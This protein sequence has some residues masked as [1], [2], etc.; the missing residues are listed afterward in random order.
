MTNP[1]ARH[2]TALALRTNIEGFIEDYGLAHCGLLT[3]V[4]PRKITWK[5]AAQNV[6]RLQRVVF[7]RDFIAWIGVVE[8][9]KDGRPHFHFLVATKENLRC[10]YDFEA[11]ELAAA[12]DRRAKF[13][14]R[15][16]TPLEATTYK[17]LIVQSAE[18]AEGLRA[19]W[20]PFRRKLPHYQFGRQYPGSLEPIRDALAISGYLAK[21]FGDAALPRPTEMKGARLVRYSL[22]VNRRAN[23]NFAWNGPRGQERRQQLASVGNILGVKEGKFAGVFGRRWNFHFMELSDYLTAR[24]GS[25][26]HGADW[27]AERIREAAALFMPRHDHDATGISS[28]RYDD[29]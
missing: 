18:H 20:E 8:L 1:Y 14:M 11:R 27:S 2:K 10:G 9:H 19:V 13:Q 29:P 15:H 25:L 6:Q 21:S 17:Q 12:I 3:L 23:Q 16:L 7:D 26:A 5:Q 22:G 28:S 4:C 24:Y